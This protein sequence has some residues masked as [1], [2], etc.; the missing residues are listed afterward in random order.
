[1]CVKCSS[2]YTCSLQVPEDHCHEHGQDAAHQNVIA[3]EASLPTPRQS[4]W[5]PS[6]ARCEEGGGPRGSCQ[7]RD[8]SDACGGVVPRPS[9]SIL[10]SFLSWLVAVQPPRSSRIRSRS[11]T[12]SPRAAEQAR[13]PH[14]QQCPR[15][16]RDTRCTR[17]PRHTGNP[18][19]LPGIRER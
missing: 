2:L 17:V 3:V 15:D 1:M 4:N 8:A 14:V 11:S 12:G 9:L 18:C 5:R 7:L 19:S 10:S 6:G 16:P 13:D